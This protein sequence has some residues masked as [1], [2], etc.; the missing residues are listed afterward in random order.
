MFGSQARQ[1]RNDRIKDADKLAADLK[2]RADDHRKE[3]AKTVRDAKTGT[4]PDHAWARGWEK[5]CAP[6]QN[7]LDANARDWADVAAQ[8]KKRWW[9]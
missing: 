4:F 2:R 6:N 9:Q 1:E 5:Q 8:M 7:V 3:T